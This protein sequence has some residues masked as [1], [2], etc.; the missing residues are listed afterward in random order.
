LELS[1]IG[2]WCQARV[3]DV[4]DGFLVAL[5]LFAT[6][7]FGALAAGLVIF[8]LGISWELLN[9]DVPRTGDYPEIIDLIG[10]GVGALVW[11]G[12]AGQA[13]TR[14]GMNGFTRT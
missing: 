14:N 5:L 9:P 4:M 11:C 6:A 2:E 12:C 3:Y 7:L 8:V 1:E 13:F 10:V